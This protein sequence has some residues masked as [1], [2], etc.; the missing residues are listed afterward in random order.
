MI[1]IFSMINPTGGNASQHEA[2]LHQF[3][4]F[5]RQTQPFFVE[6]DPRP[7]RE[8]GKGLLAPEYE[9][10]KR[11]FFGLN[12][13]FQIKRH[14]SYNQFPEPLKSSVAQNPNLGLFT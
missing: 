7:F 8:Y 13:E 4:S 9:V 10:G 2:E 11:Q 14:D 1:V 6:G 5:L 12:F 3:L